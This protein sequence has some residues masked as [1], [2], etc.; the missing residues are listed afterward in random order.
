MAEETK[1][2]LQQEREELE[3]EN[4]REEVGRK[5]AERE[6]RKNASVENEKSF[7][8]QEVSQRETQARCNHK[9]GGRDYASLQ[10]RGDGENHSIIS[11][12]YPVGG[13]M[14]YHCTHCQFTWW[15]GTTEAHMADKK[16]PN[17][18]GISYIQASK[19]PTD[20]TPAGSVIFGPKVA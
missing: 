18:T 7:R 3:L 14:L 6:M 20:N 19:L 16:T 11:W 10:K 2:T 12:Q 8:A 4:L 15:P 5:R 9:K 13:F 1:K 17:P